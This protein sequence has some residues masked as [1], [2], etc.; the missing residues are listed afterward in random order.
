VLLGQ[1]K[2]MTTKY[3]SYTCSIT[4]VRLGPIVL[5]INYEQKNGSKSL[6]SPP[7]ISP[8]KSPQKNRS[9][10][11]DEIPSSQQAFTLPR[12]KRVSTICVTGSRT[13]RRDAPRQR[14]PSLFFENALTRE[15][16]QFVCN[17]GPSHTLDKTRTFKTVFTRSVPELNRTS[18][19]L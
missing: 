18:S 5:R 8:I 15:P 7:P 2:L 4:R 16:A 17:T 3:G 1:R 6:T 11:E 19:G 9:D 13:L 14:S 12:R 10:S